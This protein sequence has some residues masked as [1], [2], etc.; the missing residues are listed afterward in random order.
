MFTERQTVQNTQPCPGGREDS[1][2]AHP[3]KARFLSALTHHLKPVSSMG[4]TLAYTAPRR[5]QDTPP[6]EKKS[7]ARARRCATPAGRRV[8]FFLPQ[9]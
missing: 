3:G 7:P 4:L 2:P 1:N 5:H 8:F 6:P 9:R